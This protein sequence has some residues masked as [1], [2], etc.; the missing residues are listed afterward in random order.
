MNEKPN[1]KDFLAA[2]KKLPEKMK[3]FLFS[4]SLTKIVEEICDEN[5][6][7]NVVDFST[8]IGGLLVGLLPIENIKN[9][10]KEISAPNEKIDNIYKEIMEK[11][12]LTAKENLGQVYVQKNNAKANDKNNKSFTA[13]VYRE[14]VK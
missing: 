3:E 2:Y 12:V 7:E 10:L 8:I 6:I 14:P 9:D 13:D 5:E 1:Q 11:I 4:D